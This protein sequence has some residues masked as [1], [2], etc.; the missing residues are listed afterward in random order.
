MERQIEDI[1]QIAEL[2]TQVTP[3]EKVT[4]NGIKK[5]IDFFKRTDEKELPI[6]QIE[7]PIEDDPYTTQNAQDHDDYDDGDYKPKE[8]NNFYEKS[9]DIEK[10]FDVEIKPSTDTSS[11]ID[12]VEKWD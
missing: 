5:L 10:S 2:N 4:R 8:Q 1:E 9:E 11:V 7:T 3:P 12:E 6:K